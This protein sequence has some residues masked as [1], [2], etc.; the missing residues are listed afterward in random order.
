MPAT[1]RV[2]AGSKWTVYKYE[3]GCMATEKVQCP[4][5]TACN[6]PRPFKHECPKNVSLDTPI[7]VAAVPDGMSC[8]VEYA[9]VTCPPNTACNPPR[10][11]PVACPRR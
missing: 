1:Q 8:V 10:P 4:P 5:N 7:T 9:P 3:D 2:P 11:T 6:P